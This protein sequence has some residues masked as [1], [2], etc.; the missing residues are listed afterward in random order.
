[1]RITNPL[2]LVLLGVALCLSA[3]V[4]AAEPRDG[5]QDPAPMADFPRGDATSDA[6][7]FLLRAPAIRRDLALQAQQVESLEQLIQEVDEPLW[8][9]R[10]AQ[11]LNAREL[12]EGLAT[13]RAARVEARRDSEAGA[14]RQASATRLAGEGTSCPAVQRRDSRAQALPGSGAP[15]CGDLR[16]N[17]QGDPATPEGI[18][19]QG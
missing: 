9:L 4:R 12:A 7:L 11:F 14:A 2:L 3:N 16:G 18:G 15:D 1:M 17:P 6:L 19:G 13:D 8:R 5:K 10:D